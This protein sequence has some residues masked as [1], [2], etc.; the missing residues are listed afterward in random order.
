MSQENMDV[1]CRYYEAINREDVAAALAEVDPN[2][3]WWVRWDQPDQSVV[4]GHDAWT[5]QWDEIYATF[6]DFRMDPMEFIDAG[7]F[8]VVPVFQVG[9]FQDSDALIEQHE[10]H[11]WKLSD[12]KIV[13]VR[14]FNDK[15]DALKAAGLAE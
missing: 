9:R 10:V 3:E 7:D 12:G 6:A 1:V 14:E 5:A 11:V 2:V 13:E 8:V 15:A 4:R